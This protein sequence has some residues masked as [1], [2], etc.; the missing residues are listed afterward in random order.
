MLPEK[1]GDCFSIYQKFLKWKKREIWKALFEHFQE[2]D[3]E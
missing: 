1:Y 3:G 2:I